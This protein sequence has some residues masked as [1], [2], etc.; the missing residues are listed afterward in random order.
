MQVSARQ[1]L[2]QEKLAARELADK[3]V[4]VLTPK[5]W[6]M[7]EQGIGHTTAAME[8]RQTQALVNKIRSD[9]QALHAEMKA[10]YSWFYLPKWLDKSLKQTCEFQVNQKYAKDIGKTTADLS[11]WDKLDFKRLIHETDPEKKQRFSELLAQV[12]SQAVKRQKAYQSQIPIPAKNIL[13]GNISPSVRLQEGVIL[14]ADI[15]EGEIK[16][17]L[18]IDP[19]QDDALKNFLA[20]PQVKA[21]KGRLSI[22]TIDDEAKYLEDVTS[23]T[24]SR[25][26]KAVDLEKYEN[27]RLIA[28]P[29]ETFPDTYIMSGKQ[30]YIPIQKLGHALNDESGVCLHKAAVNKLILDELSHPGV[31]T[32]LKSGFLKMDPKVYPQLPPYTKPNSLRRHAW[33]TVT[34][35]SGR[36]WL[37]DSENNFAALLSFKDQAGVKN[38][39]SYALNPATKMIEN[40]KAR[41]MENTKATYLTINQLQKQGKGASW[42]RWIFKNK[43]SND[44]PNL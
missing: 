14:P 9:S 26:N 7:D 37:I 23:L 36:K 24:R 39:P 28:R 1:L 19:S 35:P 18:I 32:S 34:F 40:P 10:R 43:W 29:L 16:A 25:L 3:A 15:Q 38:V 13:S 17:G 22:K 11:L 2:L 44:Y 41:M 12:K 42:L 31:E 5:V 21:L 27:D 6:H 33:N 20:S 8:H 30:D 4:N